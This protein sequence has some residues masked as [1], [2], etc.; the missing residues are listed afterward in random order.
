VGVY[1]NDVIKEY[2]SVQFHIWII[3]SLLKTGST[4]HYM[5]HIGSILFSCW[6]YI[7][8]LFPFVFSCLIRLCLVRGARLFQKSR[9]RLKIQSASRVIWIKFHVEQL[10]NFKSPR[11]CSERVLCAPCCQYH[12]WLI[13]YS[14]L[15]WCAWRSYSS[16]I[17]LQYGSV[18]ELCD[19]S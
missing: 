14:C 6:I 19:V 15:C 11:W 4:A 18:F 13:L 7:H 9:S 1:T 16:V 3:S 2:F 17:H 5:E 8:D 12:G 10:Q